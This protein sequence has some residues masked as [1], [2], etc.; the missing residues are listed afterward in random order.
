LLSSAEF[1]RIVDRADLFE[2]LVR[3]QASTHSIVLVLV[4]VLVLE[5]LV[6]PS[7]MEWPRNEFC[8]DSTAD[9]TN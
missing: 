6:R 8:G 1:V 2:R 4:V 7:G 9:I 5:R 3:G